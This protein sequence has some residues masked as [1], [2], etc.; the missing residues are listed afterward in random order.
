[1]S[2]TTLNSGAKK[3]YCSDVDRFGSGDCEKQCAYCGKSAVDRDAIIEECAR[4][5]EK[6]MYPSPGEA[7]DAIRDLKKE[8]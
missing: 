2:A 8:K 6:M 5:V 1:M 7:A 4:T 3:F